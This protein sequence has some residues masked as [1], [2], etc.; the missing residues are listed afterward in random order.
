M[1]GG[2]GVGIRLLFRAILLL[3][4][5]LPL[6]VV[7]AVAMCLQQ[8]PLVTRTAQLTPQDIERAKR[9]FDGHDPRKAGPGGLQTVALEERDVDLMLNYLANRLGRG[10]ARVVLRPGVAWLQAS[11]DLPRTRLAAT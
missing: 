2:R 6:F 5:A 9:I 8:E 11:L 1:S 4:V 3:L 7:V 10:A